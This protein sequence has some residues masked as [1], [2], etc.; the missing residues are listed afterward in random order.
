M[1]GSDKPKMADV[2]ALPLKVEEGYEGD[3]EYYFV[4]DADGTEVFVGAMENEQEAEALVCAVKTHDTQAQEL[5]ELK[6]K[7]AEAMGKLLAIRA[8]ANAPEASHGDA[9]FALASIL[10]ITIK[11]P[12]LDTTGRGGV[13]KTNQEGDK[14]NGTE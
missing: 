7:L 6:G 12:V 14:Q 1:M 5:A 11:G 3:Q 10:S 13:E 9:Q 4:V 8:I 2:W